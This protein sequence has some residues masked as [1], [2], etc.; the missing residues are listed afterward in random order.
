[1]KLLNRKKEFLTK[2]IVISLVRLLLL[3]VAALAFVLSVPAHAQDFDTY[4]VRL[5]GFWAY[6]T[7]SGSLQGSADSGTID[8]QQDLGFKSYSTFV[9][10]VDWKFTRKN[11]LYFVATPF[12]S[13]RQ[14]ILDRTIDFQ[15][16]TF[17]AGATIQ[18]S[19]KSYLY[20]PGYQYDIIRRKRGH[21][22][23]GVRVDL[24]DASA[25]ISAAAVNGS[26]TETATGSLLAPIPV[27]GPEFRLYLTNSPKLLSKATST[28]CTSV[29]TGTLSRRPTRLGGL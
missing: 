7:P 10:K 26:Q 13:S 25:K 14:T 27:G 28:G 12:N 1:M 18:S 3:G 22:G 6:S 15:G 20:T 21:L 2:V 11:H 19:L 5:S 16:Q 23:I 4:K 9:G 29:P 24:F 17:V 8:V